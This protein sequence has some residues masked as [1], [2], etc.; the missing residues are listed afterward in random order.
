MTRSEEAEAFFHVVYTAV[1]QIPYGKVTTYG[2]I[3]KL[4]GTPER[5]RQV[6]ICLKHLP[7]D[8]ESHFNH[9]NVPWQRVINAK[10]MISPRSQPSGARNQAAALRA[11][12]VTVTTSALGELM[13]DFSEC[14]WFPNAL[15]SEAEEDDD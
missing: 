7:Q 2:H 6:G 3:A 1:Q 11:E 14:G 15:P 10:G 12:G 5:P 8:T 4:I 13:V 9:D